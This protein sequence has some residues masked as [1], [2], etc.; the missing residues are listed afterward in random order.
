MKGVIFRDGFGWSFRIW[1][2]AGV[3]RAMV[4]PENGMPRWKMSDEDLHDLMN[5][6]KMLE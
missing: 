3:L 2:I 1:L 4:R 5:Y 6:L